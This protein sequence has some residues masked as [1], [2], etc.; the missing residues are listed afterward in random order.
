M[1]VLFVNLSNLKGK[2]LLGN[3]YRLA[4]F[5]KIAAINKKITTYFC[6]YDYSEILHNGHKENDKKLIALCN[7]SS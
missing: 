3:K 6:V 2:K 5:W 4:F 7:F 1:N